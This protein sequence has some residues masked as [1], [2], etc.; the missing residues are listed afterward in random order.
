[1]DGFEDS[2]TT[3]FFEATTSEKNNANSTVPMIFDVEQEK[4]PNSTEEANTLEQHNE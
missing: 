2:T 3:L 1:M 4:S